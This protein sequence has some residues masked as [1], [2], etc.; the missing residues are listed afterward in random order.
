MIGGWVVTGLCY[1]GISVEAFVIL[2]TIRSGSIFLS[3]GQY[4][5]F[6]VDIWVRLYLPVVFRT[7]RPL[8]E[9]SLDPQSVCLAL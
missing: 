7:T 5:C 8:G 1:G 4:V 3:D 6:P 9:M 2:K